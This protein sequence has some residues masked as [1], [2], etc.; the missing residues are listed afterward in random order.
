MSIWRDMPPLTALRAFAAFAEAGTMERA[1]VLIG[2]T[3]AAVSQQIR[4]LE[5]RMRLKLVTRSSRGLALTT[6]GLRLAQALRDGFGQIH[7]AVEELSEAETERPLHLTTTP[8][9]ASGWLLPRLAQFRAAHPVPDLM[10]DASPER[11]Q[12]GP[13]GVDLAIRYGN[14]DW[15]GVQATMLLPTSVVVV[16]A[17]DLVTGR[18]LREPADLMAFPWLQELGTTEAS[19]LFH[20]F[21]LVGTAPLGILSLPGT[22]LMDAARDGQ[23]IGAVARVFVE[24]DIAAGRLQVLFEDTSRKGYFLVTKPGVQ[25]PAVKRFCGWAL[26]QIAQNGR[27]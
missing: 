2:V 11:R 7:A 22:L 6:E 16:G 13:G 9:F 18:T 17:P 20:Q 21:G 25:R 5:D 15:P 26:R 8:A 19:G 14:G 3:H 24:A 1:G 10:V 4:A 12:I 23:G 27:A